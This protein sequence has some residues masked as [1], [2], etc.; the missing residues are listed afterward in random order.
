M[1]DFHQLA[2]SVRPAK[3]VFSEIFCDNVGKGGR[4]MCPSS[5]F[6]TFSPCFL[7]F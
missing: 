7:M 6:S 5:S 3:I 4:E 2:D 1:D